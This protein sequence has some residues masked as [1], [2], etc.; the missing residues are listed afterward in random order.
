[1]SLSPM[2]AMARPGGGGGAL[3]YQMA[4]HCQ[5][6]K[7]GGGGALRYQ[8]ATHCQMAKRG[9]GGGTQ[10]PNGYP[11]PNGQTGGGGGGHSGTKGYPL[12]NG[13][14]G[15]GALRYQMATHC[16]MAKQGGGALRYQMATHC[17]MA[18]QGGGGHSGTKWLPTAKWP[19]RGGGGGT[20]VP[21]GYP[22]PNGHTE[23]KR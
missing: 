8:M 2:G 6:A 3:R 11:L 4:T 16:Q 14:A 9:G 18:K 20:Q 23:R 19:S 5:M 13:Q 15:G 22:L 7:Q 12:P 21:N 1:M 17:Q 10:V